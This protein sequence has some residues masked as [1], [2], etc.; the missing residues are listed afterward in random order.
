MNSEQQTAEIKVTGMSCEHCVAA[1]GKAARSVPGVTEALVD[2]KA[3]TVKVQG[4]FERA[5][6]VEAIKAAGYE[7]R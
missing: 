5:Q 7:A 3:G 2:L 6:V 4:A 1:V